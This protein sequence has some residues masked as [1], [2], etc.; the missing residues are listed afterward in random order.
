MLTFLGGT[1]GVLM[2]A[3]ACFLLTEIMGWSI[4]LPA[5][6]VAIAPLG[7]ALVGI[8]FGYYPAHQ[9]ARLDPIDALRHE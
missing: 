8:F 1:L 3:I 7:S 5:D 6:A 4:T 2:G 9:A